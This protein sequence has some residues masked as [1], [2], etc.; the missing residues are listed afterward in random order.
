M[1]NQKRFIVL[2]LLLLLNFS[3]VSFAKPGEIIYLI[4]EGFTGGVI[5]VFN[6]PDGI[7]PETDKDGA[8]TYK[9]PKDGLIKVKE[10]LSKNA[11]QL[12]YYFVD[13]QGKRTSIEYLYPKNYLKN[14]SGTVT[15]NFDE[16]TED[17]S[18]NKIFASFHETK[19]FFVGKEK[20]YIHSFIVEKPANT[21]KAYLKTSDRMFDIQEELLRKEE[22][23]TKQQ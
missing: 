3:C 20:T 7:T 13:G 12:K 22:A 18:D 2:L 8:I 9:I 21:L 10:P 6:Q 4:P 16:V 1:R 17:E 15:R 11:Y 5:I 23:K 14:P 19:N